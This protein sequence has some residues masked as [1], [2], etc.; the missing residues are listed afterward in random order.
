MRASSVVEEVIGAIRTVVAFGGEHSESTRYDTLLKPALKAGKWKGAFSGLSD[1]VMKAMMFIVGAGAFW[2]GANLILHDRASDMPIEDRKY[3]PAIVMIVI[4]GIIVGAN[5]L[6]RTSPFLETFAMARG[7]ARAIYDVID[8]VS[9]I[10]PLSKAGK[11][12]NYGLK[13]NIEFRDVFFQYP[14]RKDIIVL[15]GLNVT[16]KEGQTVAL[17]GSSGCGKSTCVQL[18]QRFYDPVFGQVFLDGEDVRKYNLNWLR[19]NI[20]V[21][22]QEPVLFQGTIGWYI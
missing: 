15:R 9:L 14:A 13:G 10:D 7:S 16:V 11:I 17:V 6:S 18:L 20:A 22:G 2:Y 12:L 1:T 3:T 4:S 19:S 21:V 5:Q 8:R